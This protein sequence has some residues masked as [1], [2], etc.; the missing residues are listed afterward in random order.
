MVVSA[1]WQ[2]LIDQAKYDSSVAVWLFEHAMSVVFVFW[3]HSIIRYRPFA[4]Q[5][6]LSSPSAPVAFAMLW[7]AT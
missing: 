3:F 5:W 1:F 4:N 6:Q 2:S 7:K